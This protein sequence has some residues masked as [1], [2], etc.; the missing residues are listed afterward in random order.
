MKSYGLYLYIWLYI[1]YIYTWANNIVYK[2]YILYIERKPVYIE[3]YNM[4][5]K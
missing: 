1:V 4:H 5:F 2:V 3:L